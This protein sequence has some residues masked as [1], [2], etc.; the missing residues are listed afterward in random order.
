MISTLCD[1]TKISFNTAFKVPLGW[2][3]YNAQGYKN[4]LS[5]K[6]ENVIGTILT[7]NK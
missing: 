6:L 3:E 4:F 7:K 2:E 1:D 5:K